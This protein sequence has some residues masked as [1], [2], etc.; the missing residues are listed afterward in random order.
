[1]K[2]RTPVSGESSIIASQFT[3]LK[4]LNVRQGDSS[5]YRQNT[6][7]LHW[8]APSDTGCVPVASYIIEA[9]INGV[10][11]VVGGPFTGLVGTADLSS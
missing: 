8:Q 2:S 10:F 3:S 1:M 9:K 11:T 7:T 6:I 4:P 5:T